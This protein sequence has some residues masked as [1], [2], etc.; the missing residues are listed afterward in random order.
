MPRTGLLIALLVA[1]FTAACGG[2][3]DTPDEKSAKNDFDALTVTAVDSAR[4]IGAGDDAANW[5]SH[6][7]TY[8]E[9]RFS[10]LLDIDRDNVGMGVRRDNED[11][12]ERFMQE[13]L[14]EAP[15]L[16]RES[17]ATLR[18]L[19]KLLAELKGDPSQMIHRPPTDA[20]EMDP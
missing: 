3:K 4:L 2:S 6:G 15:A 7:R 19:E 17:R 5:L 12:F 18:D 10:P 11:D 16:L 9:Q 13:G 1:A 8:D 14:G 20:L